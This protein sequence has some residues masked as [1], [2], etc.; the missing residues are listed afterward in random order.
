MVKVPERLRM[1]K[2]NKFYL[3]AFVLILFSAPVHAEI[4]FTSGWHSL[5]RFLRLDMTKTVNSYVIPPAPQCTDVNVGRI[6]ASDPAPEPPSEPLEPNAGMGTN[7]ADESLSIRDKIMANYTKLGGDPI[8][9]EQSLCFFDKYKGSKFKAAGDPSRANGIKIDN[10]RYIT[11]ND[12]NSSMSKSRFY[13]IDMETGKV[14]TYFSSHGYGGK[15]GVPESDMMAEGLSNVDGSNASPRG[16]FITGTRREGSSDPRWKYSMKLH[17]LQQGVNDKSFSRA[18]IMHPFPKMPEESASSDDPEVNGA[19]RS[20]GPFSL[21]QGCPML[22]EKH[23]SEIINKIKSPSN[24]QGGSLYYNYSPEEK[25][26]G[27]SYCGDE[28]L[29]KK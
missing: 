8:A 9:L 16:F 10:Q 1:Q 25:S 20:E 27:A 15:K 19:I 2:L 17:G 14:N 4:S 21:S 18:V 13:V 22:S 12:L 5:M 24:A 11:I 28:G 23:A 29:M 26:R 7:V 6:V 3:T